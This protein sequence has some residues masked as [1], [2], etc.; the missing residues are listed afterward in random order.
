MVMISAILRFVQEFKSNTAASKL[1][2]MVETTAT[3]LR[4]KTRKEI[5]MHDI[6]PGDI[7]YLSAG[8]MVPADC[9]IIQ[10]KDL[11]VVQSSLTGESLPVESTAVVMPIEYSS[12]TVG[13]AQFLSRC[14]SIHIG[15]LLCYLKQF[16][17]ILL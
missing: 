12:P 6:V 3:A 4:D 7:I 14:C 16:F 5:D 1:K 15:S 13:K 17:P 10:S 2:D 9:R 8:D 11:F